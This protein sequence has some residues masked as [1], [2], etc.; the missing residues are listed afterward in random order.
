MAM[1]GLTGGAL[2]VYF[3]LGKA[4]PRNISAFLSRIST[5]FALCIAACFVLQ[6]ASPLPTV[7]WATFGVIWL[8]AILLLATPFVLGGI[9]VSLALTRIPSQSE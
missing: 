8:K 9:A 7:K 2:I 4:N 1:L 3:K 6:L 5:A